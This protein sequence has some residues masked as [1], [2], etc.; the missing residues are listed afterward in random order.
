MYQHKVLRINYTRYDMRRDQDSINLRTHPDIMT[1]A[2]DD[3][4]HPYL[5]VRVIGIFHVMAYRAGDDLEGKGDTEP[6]L[7]HVLW[8]RWFDLDLRAS[9]G[10]KARRL[11]R[12][13]WAVLDDGAFGFIAPD[14]V[15][16]AAHLM[17]A[18]AYGQSD[19]VLPGY[20]V[21]RREDE[22]D[23]DWKYHYVGMCVQFGFYCPQIL[24]RFF[25][26]F[27]DR[28]MFMRY[29]GGA[30]GHQRTG[31]GHSQPPSVVMPEPTTELLSK[32][33]DNDVDD[34]PGMG[35]SA[36]VDNLESASGNP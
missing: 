15:L 2:P 28:D 13:K 35:D 12:L 31:T 8:V 17:P 23:T 34:D 14:Q 20:T 16:R 32:A 33:Y 24:I 11:P 36:V 21:A 3:A 19:A 22:E 5:Y 10:F 25:Y 1:I 9:G 26:S 6:E 4:T 18:F 27:V 7:T 30:V 29:Y